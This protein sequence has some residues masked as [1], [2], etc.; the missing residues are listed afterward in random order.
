MRNAEL[1]CFLAGS[2]GATAKL[3]SRRNWTILVV[4][5][6]QWLLSTCALPLR[7]GGG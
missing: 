3:Y 7:S 5:A 2:A 6:V 1:L 4:I